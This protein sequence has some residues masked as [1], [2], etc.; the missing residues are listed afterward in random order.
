MNLQQLRY[1]VATADAGSMTAAARGVP[2][3]QPALS[4]AVRALEAELG[5]EL[6]ATRGRSVELTESGRR[7][8]VA[9]RRVL[10]E[11][12]ALEK[13]ASQMNEVTALTLT[14]TPTLEN[15]YTGPAV[16]RYMVD[17]PEVSIAMR[18][19]NGR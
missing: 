4:R 11:V 6:F 15:A 2:V 1:V 5:V 9:A 13:L 8:V 14:S 12:A 3:A 10:D 18:R 16:A 17:H 19:A 7:I